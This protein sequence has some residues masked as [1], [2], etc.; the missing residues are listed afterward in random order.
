MK[1]AIIVLAAMLAGCGGGGGEDFAVQVDESPARVFAS[2]TG[3]NYSTEAAIF[4]GLDIRTSRPSDNEI[5]YTMPAFET[6][7]EQSGESVIA[8]TLEPAN[9]GSS[10]IVHAAVDVP[11]VRMMMGEANKVLSEKLVEAELH[12]VLKGNSRS[13]GTKALLVAV[14]IAS[15]AKHQ[16]TVNLAKSNPSALADI[17][18]RASGLDS[19]SVAFK[20]DGQSPMSN[21]DY[22]AARSMGDIDRARGAEI[23]AFDPTPD[24]DFG[25]P[26]QDAF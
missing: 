4:S 12:R 8:L 23:E 2:L 19:G 20:S 9:D 24:S 7:M 26:H 18:G 11:Q 15:N 5:V 22:D 21:P 1:K 14:A 10:T 25:K 17:L 13:S 6:P 3:F 16:S